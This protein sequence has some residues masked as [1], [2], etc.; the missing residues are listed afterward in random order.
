[1]GSPPPPSRLLAA[2]LFAQ[3]TLNNQLTVEPAD[4][5]EIEAALVAVAAAAAVGAA[6]FKAATREHLGALTNKM[7]QRPERERFPPLLMLLL[8]GHVPCNLVEFAAIWSLL[9]VY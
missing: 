3:R 2:F 5:G 6:G 1:M 4:L 7:N 8:V 9:L